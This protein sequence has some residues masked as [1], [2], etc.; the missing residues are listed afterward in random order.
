MKLTRSRT[1]K[2]RKQKLAQKSRPDSVGLSLVL[3]ESLSNM[4]IEL[5]T[6]SGSI[7]TDF[8]GVTES[9]TRLM[10]CS[11]FSSSLGRESSLDL[12]GARPTSINGLEFLSS[13]SRTGWALNDWL[14]V[15]SLRC[16]F[17]AQ[18]LTNQLHSL[19]L[20]PVDSR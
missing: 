7:D 16:E 18:L 19:V 15:R 6:R 5:C 4:Q 3:R 14:C 20:H 10:I 1:T 11:Q 2:R 9:K 13:Q 8:R 17:E 12:S